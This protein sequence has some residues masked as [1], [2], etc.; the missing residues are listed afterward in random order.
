MKRFGFFKGS[1]NKENRKVL[2]F[3]MSKERQ[4][5]ADEV[6]HARRE[7]VICRQSFFILEGKF[8]RQTK[9]FTDQNHLL[10]TGK[11]S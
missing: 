9:K 2:I 5:F 8:R 11:Q 6:F 10:L 7:A 4:S 1:D 3:F